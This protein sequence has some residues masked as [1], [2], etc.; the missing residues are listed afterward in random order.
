[1]SLPE[2]FLNASERAKPDPREKALFLEEWDLKG[3]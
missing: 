1:M 3:G 2:Q